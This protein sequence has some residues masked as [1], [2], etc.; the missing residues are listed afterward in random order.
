MIAP[1]FT[2]VIATD[3]QTSGANV[4]AVSGSFDPTQPYTEIWMADGQT[5]RLPTSVL[6]QAAVDGDGPVLDGAEVP[7]IDSATTAIQL[8]E[9]RLEVGKRTVATG[10]VRLHKTVQE[11]TEALDEVL[12][13][14]T[15]DVERRVLNQPVDAPPPV[16]QE[17]TTTVYSL[18]EE[19]LIITKQLVLKEEVRVVQRD[20]ERRDT[21]VV[22]LRKEHLTVERSNPEH[23]T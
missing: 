12:A 9:E 20:T 2:Q 6:I 4:L 19:Q 14:R 23:T 18:V 7:L 22:T 5:L 11:Y 15:F 21:Q 17:G 3:Q 10:V 8:V 1:D 16:R 13:V